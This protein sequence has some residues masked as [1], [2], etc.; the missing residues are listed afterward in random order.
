MSRCVVK[1]FT[2]VM[3]NLFVVTLLSALFLLGPLAK[4]YV[5]DTS[6]SVNLSVV[7]PTACS[8]SLTNINQ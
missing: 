3:G 1:V 5:E 8:L 6:A 2:M 4:A 7:V